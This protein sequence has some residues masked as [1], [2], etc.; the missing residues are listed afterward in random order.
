MTTMTDR[1]ALVTGASSGIGRATAE[2]FAANGARVVVAAR[3]QEE[4][5]ALVAAIEAR[6]GQASAICTDVSEARDVERMV[7]HVMTVYGRLDYAVN[8]AGIEGTLAGIA[9]LAEDDWDRV[10]DINLKGTFLCMKYEARAMLNGGWG[11]AIV[12]VGSVNSFLGFPTGAAYVTSKHGLIGLTTSVSAELAPQGIRVNLVCP[13]VV[14]TP[15][16]RRL[17][18]V[19]GDEIYDKG[20]FPRVHLRRAA[21]SDEIAQSI[22]FLCSDDA[23]YITGTTLT[24]DGGFTLTL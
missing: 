18:D 12:N 4:L 23:S 9:D 15:M 24:P 3:R 5:D 10:L 17:R 2:A 14:E 22:V 1:V 6:G 13:G 11:R 8:N 20:L 16:H 19:V 7:D 21:R